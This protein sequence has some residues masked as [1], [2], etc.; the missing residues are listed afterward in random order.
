MIKDFESKNDKEDSNISNIKRKN[1]RRTTKY[2]KSDILKKYNYLEQ[3]S[4]KV[5]HWKTIEVI[6]INNNI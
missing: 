5:I 1:S 2:I 4:L 6:K 3:N